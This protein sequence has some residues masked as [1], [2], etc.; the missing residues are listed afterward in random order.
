MLNE[1]M[2]FMKE[3]KIIFVRSANSTHD[4]VICERTKAGFREYTF[5]EDCGD[6]DILYERYTISDVT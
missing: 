1:L 3:H 2:E 4:L 6:M 5:E